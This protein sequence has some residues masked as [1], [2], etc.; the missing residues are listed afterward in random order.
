MQNF[1]T[2]VRE[3]R[4][5]SIVVVVCVTA[6]LIYALSQGVDLTWIPETIKS[7]L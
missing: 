7:L 2:F 6:I 1:L 3:N 4:T 5:L